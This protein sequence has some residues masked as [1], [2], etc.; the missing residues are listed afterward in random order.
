MPHS[1]HGVS[2]GLER[3]EDNYF[4]TLKATGKLT[5]GDYEKITPILESALEGVKEESICVLFDATEL[6]GWALRAA[7]DD[8]QLGLKF[9]KKFSK[10]AVYGNKTWQEYA[11]KI[12]SWFVSGDVQFFETRD[13]ALRFLKES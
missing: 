6:E 12:G 8:L 9:D 5:H 13:D 4:V 2:I 7:W 11:T 10:I 1:R 3:I